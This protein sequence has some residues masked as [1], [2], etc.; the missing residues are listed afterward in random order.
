MSTKISKGARSHLLR[1]V[2]RLEFP[3]FTVR[4]VG[5][6]KMNRQIREGLAALANLGQAFT[7]PK[8]CEF[9][10]VSLRV[11]PDTTIEKG[12]M[13]TVGADGLARPA[14]VGRLA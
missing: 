13:V 8:D 4:L 10:V 2:E 3:M 7:L 1:V 6:H 12:Q 11:A 14:A 9:N 5:A